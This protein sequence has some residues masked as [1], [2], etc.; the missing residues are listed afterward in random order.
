[1]RISLDIGNLSIVIFWHWEFTK[2]HPQH[3]LEIFGKGSFVSILFW[4]AFSKPPGYLPQLITVT[5]IKRVAEM[6]WGSVIDPDPKTPLL[7]YVS[8]RDPDW[9][10]YGKCQEKPSLFLSRAKKGKE[11]R[12]LSNAMFC[13]K[14]PMLILGIVSIGTR[15][16]LIILCKT[17][18][19]LEMN[20]PRPI[21]KDI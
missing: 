16:L 10:W 6:N 21:Y 19:C 12:K 7:Q 20:V 8:W 17:Y 5:R 11:S 4:K 15:V 14:E 13:F 9:H 3:Y 18:G 2:I 1:M